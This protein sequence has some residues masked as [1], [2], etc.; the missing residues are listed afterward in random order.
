[1]PASR[2]LPAGIGQAFRAPSED[3][4]KGDFQSLSGLLE[5]ARTRP[6]GAAFRGRQRIEPLTRRDG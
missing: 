4:L 6:C 1:M 2:L 3:V 5:L